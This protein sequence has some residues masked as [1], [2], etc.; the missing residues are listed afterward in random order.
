M[1]RNKPLS[2]EEKCK[3]LR[4]LFSETK[5]VYL[6]K[7]V[8]KVASKTKGIVEKTVEEVLKEVVDDGHIHSEKIGTSIYFWAFPSESIVKVSL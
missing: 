2:K 3:R 4:E 1:S 5:D 7:E 8:E 6:L